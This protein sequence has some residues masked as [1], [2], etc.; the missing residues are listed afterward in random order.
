MK[1]SLIVAMSLA[2]AS[3]AV[4]AQTAPLERTEIL[5]RLALGY[6]PSYIAHLVKTR[7][8]SFSVSLNFLDQVNLAGGKGILADNLPHASS[9]TSMIFPNEDARPDHLAK[10]AELIHIGDTE[11]AL[12]ECRASI[13]ES[14]ASPWPLLVTATLL[15]P[16]SEASG[17]REPGDA[18]NN[19]RTT[20]IRRAAALAPSV[21]AA[22][23]ALAQSSNSDDEWQRAISLDAEQLETVEA[24]RDI[25]EDWPLSALFSNDNENVSPPNSNAP[26]VIPSELV[27]RIQA[28]PDLSSNHL[29]LAGIY[30]KADD[31]ERAQSEFQDAID[32]EPD[33][34]FN[35]M[36]L[37]EFY[38]NHERSEANV[39]ELREA[40]RIAPFN[41]AARIKLAKTLDSLGRTSDA[42]QE[43]RATLGVRPED[44]DA[45]KALVDLYVKNK[46]RKS[47]IEELRRSL[48]ASLVSM[49][50]ES[51]VVES[52]LSDERHLA[53]LLED[54]YQLDA[55]AAQYVYLLRFYPDDLGIHNDYGTVLMGQHRCDQAIGEYK[56]ALRL[57]PQMSEAHHNIGLCLEIQK[58]YDAAINE[59]REAINLNPDSPH[60]RAL[61]GE[62]LERKGDLQ[63][64][65]NEFRELI[66]RDPKDVQ[67]YFGLSET[68][69]ALRDDSGAIE[70]LK[71]ILELDPN[72]S[73]AKNDLAWIYATADDPKLRNPSEALR[74]AQQAVDAL[75][76][77]AYIDTLA[78][79]LLINGK[80]V[81]ALEKET[82]CATLS[83]KNEYFQSRLPRFRDAAAKAST[84][85]P[86]TP[87]P[88][89]KPPV[90]AH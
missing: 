76:V 25:I 19:E 23:I 59:F 46:D 86:V 31:L 66:E 3:P 17:A 49:A 28:E 34:A 52:R 20:L 43:L 77:P 48:K 78:E 38:E 63:N 71:K 12:S 24:S 39:G 30:D 89:E 60:S 84:S 83:P 36:V 8:L 80:A 45:D 61:I 54:S 15:Q 55:A 74:L 10:C 73:A 27:H 42:I 1:Y 9:T 18:T 70:E 62:A 29:A 79:A 41:V 37:A 2:V 26:V 72:S 57:D 33:V 13:T 88:P 65:A 51:K 69:S 5:G 50:D 56:E 47:A 75:Q 40:T 7:G 90:P 53:Q 14:P 82:Q 32:L 11:S 68:L 81:E 85:G 87:S 21:A 58:D 22:H 6:S 44:T 64:A 35:H 67:G 4:F 16:S